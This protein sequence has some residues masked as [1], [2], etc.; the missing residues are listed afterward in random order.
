MEQRALSPLR[1]GVGMCEDYVAA[2]TL[3]LRDMGLRA[4]Y[5]PGLIYS[6]EGH[7]VDHAWTI[8]QID[9]VWYHLDS[10]LEDNISCR[11]SVRYRYLLNSDTT[12]AA[13]HRWGQNLKQNAQIVQNY[14]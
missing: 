4:E 1:F 14:L 10:Q 7:L 13:S 12:R 5:V 3:L 11:G 8:V 6:V 2:L 9:G